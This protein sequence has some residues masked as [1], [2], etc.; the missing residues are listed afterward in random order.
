M[1]DRGLE[2]DKVENGD[3][4]FGGWVD[5]VLPRASGAKNDRVGSS[6]GRD[7]HP[8]RA[9]RPLKFAKVKR[10]LR[11]PRVVARRFFTLGGANNFQTTMG[12]LFVWSIRVLSPHRRPS[13]PPFSAA[14]RARPGIGSRP[15]AAAPHLA[16]QAGH[17]ELAVDYYRDGIA[18]HAREVGLRVELVN[19]LADMSRYAEAI[20]QL[21]AVA[22]LRPD[23]PGL[24]EAVAELEAL[25]TGSVAPR[26]PPPAPR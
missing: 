24:A 22:G 21:N 14:S 12:A 11:R 2:R 1:R 4:F 16:L 17:P 8:G 3:L 6:L 10:K 15:G 26:P 13:D 20:A 18:V 9:I 7:P 5:D 19:V 23:F 25:Q